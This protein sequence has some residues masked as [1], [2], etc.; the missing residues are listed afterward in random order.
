MNNTLL[1]HL[2]SESVENKINQY[3]G[4]RITFVTHNAEIGE[5]G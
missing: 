2:S 5:C 1:E 3:I 4:W